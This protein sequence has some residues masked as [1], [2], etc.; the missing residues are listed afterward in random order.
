VGA[1][2]ARRSRRAEVRHPGRIARHQ[3]EAVR[4]HLSQRAS[5]A[6]DPYDIYGNSR[7][8]VNGKARHHD[9]FFAVKLPSPLVCGL[10][11]VKLPFIVVS[12][13][14]RMPVNA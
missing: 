14:S 11:N 9:C 8:R 6:P 1:L 13:A 3:R 4:A 10:D 12:F 5:L 2:T 7:E